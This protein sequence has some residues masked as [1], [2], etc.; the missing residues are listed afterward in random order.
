M[1]DSMQGRLELRDLSFAYSP[2]DPPIVSGLSLTLAPGA[3]IALVGGSGSGK[4]TIGRL[5]CGLLE[6]TAGEVLLD[7]RPLQQ[8]PARVFAQAA[9]YVD[10][11]VFLFEGSLRDNLS[12]WDTSVPES[13]MQ[14]ALSDAMIASEVAHRR[15]GLDAHVNEGGSNFSGGERQRLEIARALVGSPLL[16]VLDEATSA[17]DTVTEKAIDDNLRRRGCACVIIAHRLSTIR[18]CDEIL[19]LKRGVVVERGTHESLMALQ[20]E[21]ASLVQTM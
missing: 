20:G 5:C 7:G 10:Q 1:V 11:D 3:R 19:V 4:S 9:S 6:P 8:T 13:A 15:D 16:L 17:L 2:F 14:R 12:L 18:D 21:Y